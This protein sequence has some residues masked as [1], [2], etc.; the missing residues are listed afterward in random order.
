MDIG[1]I[2]GGINGLCCAW[3]LA[4]HGHQ[5]KLY[6]RHQLMGATS[7]A[8]S[9]LLHGGHR[10]L[11]NCEFRLVREALSESNAWFLRMPELAKPLRLVM[12]TYRRARR[13]GWMIAI[14]LLLYDYMGGF[15]QLP[16]TNRLSKTEILV[17]DPDLNPEGLQGGYEFTDGHM[18]DRALGLWVADQ[19]R[20]QGV[21]I[22][23]HIAVERVSIEARLL[24]ADGEEHQ[25]DRLVNIAGPWAH[26][27]LKHS[28]IET[29]YRLDL[30]RG[31]HLKLDQSCLQAYL[32]EVP[33][34][35]RIFFVLPW[36][37]RT[38]LSTTEVRQTLDEPIACSDAERD[39][40][41]NAY[42]H[43]FPNSQPTVVSSFAGLRPLL[44]SAED[45]NKTTR[46]YAIHRTERL[47]SVFGGK[48]TTAL[49]LADKVAQ[50][51]K[52]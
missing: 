10:Y 49:A 40:L 44:Y 38:L 27:L 33:G 14:G 48:W 4:E 12:P 43:Y 19:A 21:V 23:E 6:E 39:N 17:R 31:S 9:K 34:E 13:L 1:I 41:L 46:E 42:R 7:Q 22:T 26:R 30:V 25:H 2:D 37:G 51:L 47:I 45:P 18:D 52:R 50:I 24:T 8:S 16:N 36:K 11:E 20:Q 32:F 28:G 29:P 15:R 5:V 35:R 3:R